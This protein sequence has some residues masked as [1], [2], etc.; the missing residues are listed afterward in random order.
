M[1]Y[2]MYTLMPTFLEI[3]FTITII[4]Y[5]FTPKYLY[6][7]LGTI[8]M[9]IIA[10]IIC[11]EWRAKY[12]KRLSLAD[13]VYVQKATDSLLNFETVKYFNAEDHERDRFFTSLQIYKEANITVAMTLVTLNILQACCISFGLTVTLMLAYGDIINGKLD[14]SD[15][16]TFN[17]YIIQIYFPLGFIGTFWRYIR[18]NWTDVELVLDILKT[19]EGIMDAPDA[20]DANISAGKIEFKNITFTYDSELE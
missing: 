10:T 1:R 3:A 9:Y 6:V 20:I 18:Q 19:N 5:L 7:N 11:T 14:V 13:S 16:V 12:F 8:I 17:L 2:T 15:F 4:G